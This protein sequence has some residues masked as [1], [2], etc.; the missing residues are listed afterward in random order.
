MRAL[1]I[2]LILILGAACAKTD[3]GGGSGTLFVLAEIVATS[4]TTNVEVSVM[5]RGNPVT[6]ANVA[7]T[8]D[9]TGEDINLEGRTAGIYTTT[10]HGYARTLGLQ[11]TSGNDELDAQLE[12]PAAHR[13]TRPPNDARVLR[14]DFTVLR[15]EWEAEDPADRVEVVAEKTA[16]LSLEGDT[17]EA[18]VPLATLENGDQRIA[19]TRETTVELAGGTEGSRMRS[20]YKVDNRFTLE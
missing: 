9:D 8:D 18:E 14:K 20:R 15:V 5:L 10:I 1:P 7:V 3:P 2:L 4:D 13:I 12:G 6:G 11:I 17:F 19:V 16:P